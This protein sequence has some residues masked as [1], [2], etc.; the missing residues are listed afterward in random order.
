MLR[1]T[2]PEA[3]LKFYTD[4]LGLHVIFAMNTGAW[5]IYYLGPRDVQISS[6]GTAKGL[7]ELYYIPGGPARYRNGNEN[8]GEGFGHVG[9]TV[10]DVG[11]VLERCR[12]A[13][14]KIL[15]DLGD[16]GGSTEKLGVPGFLRVEDVSEG[17]KFVFRQLAFVEDPDGY[18][19]ELVPKVVQSP[20]KD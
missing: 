6:L 17:Y 5:T 8:G 16:G 11:E 3:S 12:G 19:V 15:K 9:F 4:I 14:Y 7:L 20:P 18:W 10:P 2:N 13:G 1:I